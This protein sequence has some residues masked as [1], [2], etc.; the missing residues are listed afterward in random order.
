M[1]YFLLDTAMIK[2]VMPNAYLKENGYLH[3]T[4]AIDSKTIEALRHQINRALISYENTSEILYDKNIPLKLLYVFNKGEIFLKTLACD[5]ILDLLIENSDDPKSVVPT[6]EDVVVKMPNSQSR[7]V[8][9]QDLPMQ[10]FTGNTFSIAI[11][12]HDANDNPVYF[13]PRSYKLGAMTKNQILEIFEKE[14]NH[15]VPVRAKAGDVLL[16]YAKTVHYSM[17]NNSA[18]PRYTWYLEFRTLKQLYEDS[19]WDKEWIL[20]RRAIF[21]YALQKFN[22][23]RFAEFICDH[24]LT[25]HLNN[26]ELKIPHVTDSV[27]YDMQSPYYHF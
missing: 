15:F 13:L 2:E 24:E 6:W 10:S 3:V 21:V 11:Y 20:K 9:H 7:F 5:A 8:P 27:D 16:H 4:N 23:G 18:N 12:L 1:L 26:I 17:E 22:P 25:S 14:K 19:P